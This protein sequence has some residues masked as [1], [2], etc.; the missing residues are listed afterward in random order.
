MLMRLFSVISLIALSSTS[1]WCQSTRTPFS[2]TI[3]G[4]FRRLAVL[5]QE[6]FVANQNT[7]SLNAPLHFSGLLP[8]VGKFK[9]SLTSVRTRNWKAY[10][11]VSGTM[12]PDESKL[13]LFKGKAQLPGGQQGRVSASLFEEG[14]TPMFAI[15]LRHTRGNSGGFFALKTAVAEANQ[16]Q[17]VQIISSQRTSAVRRTPQSALTALTFDSLD[18]P[19]GTSTSSNPQNPPLRTAA[20]ELRVLLLATEADP[21]Y[22]QRYGS[23]ANNQ[24]ASV[25]AAANVIY[26]RDIATTLSITRQ[27]ARSAAAQGSVSANTLLS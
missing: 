22:S 13:L 11:E 12:V 8:T 17:L 15:Q 14:D 9:V 4:D 16:H 23:S 18:A 20:A 24:I 7:P 6:H 2:T 21:S 10:R 1:A 27:V 25:I 19:R 5:A 3:R 26:E